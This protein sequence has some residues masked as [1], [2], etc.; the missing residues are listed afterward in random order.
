MWW[1]SQR[2]AR[3]QATAPLGTAAATG[4][5]ASSRLYRSVAT[6]FLRKYIVDSRF[7]SLLRQIS[8]YIFTIFTTPANSRNLPY[9]AK[10]ITA[11]RQQQ[12]PSRRTSLTSFLFPSFLALAT[13]FRCPRRLSSSRPTSS[14]YQIWH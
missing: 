13:L 10:M 3:G 11:G 14:E 9:L 1:F 4:H 12:Q 7:G 2:E 8:T 6:T 5:C